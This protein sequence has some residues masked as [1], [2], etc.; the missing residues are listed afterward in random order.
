[1]EKYGYQLEQSYLT[2]KSGEDSA[3]RVIYDRY[4]IIP[5]V[6]HIFFRYPEE[7]LAKKQILTKDTL[8]LYE[9]ANA[10]YT[11]I[12]NGESFEDVGQSLTNG[13]N[14]IYVVME[15]IFPFHAPKS[16]EDFIFTMEPGSISS[17]IRSMHGF[18][19]VKVDRVMP[20]PGKIRVAHIL[21]AFPSAEP[22]D[23]EK[24]EARVKSEEIYQKALK[25]DDFEALAGTLSDDTTNVKSGI[26]LEF[27][28]G[29]I[30][31][32]MEKAGFGLENIGDI[33]KPF[34][35]RHGFHIFKLVDR[36]TEI[37]YEEVEANIYTTLNQSERYYDLFGS[38]VEQMKERHGFKLYP[39]AY[40][41]LQHLADENFPTD[42]IFVTRGIEM[43]KTLITI[44]TL[45]FSQGLFVEYLYNKHRTAQMY[46]LDFMKDVYDFFV[47]EIV[48]EI[49]KRSLERDY[50]DYL[51]QLK[52]YYDGI[53]LFEISNKRIWSRPVEEQEQLEAE[54]IKELNEK[55]PVV[56]NWKEIKKIKNI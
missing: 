8:A 41:E 34:Q 52:E 4:K 29:E 31:E 9:K 37:P 30:L 20:N 19:L 56:I 54:W 21:S 1:L 10:A 27:G 25:N 6:K 15:Y 53:L 33:C 17:P 51:L 48:T 3:V 7:Q 2:N 35:T 46:S 12:K 5:S 18:H 38:F 44:D 23:E 28:I 11:R 45:E 47:R 36:K 43:K 39:E 26:Y 50:P 42:S 24:E 32:P 16:V 49:E 14:V 55:Y 13:S 22:T 40:R